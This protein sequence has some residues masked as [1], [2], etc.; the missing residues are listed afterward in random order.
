MASGTRRRAKYGNK[1]GFQLG[2]VIWLVC[3]SYVT[4]RCLRER[5][6]HTAMLPGG[7]SQESIQLNIESLWSGGPFQD[8]VRGPALRL[9]VINSSLL[10]HRSR[11]TVVTVCLRSTLN[12]P[13]TCRASAKLSFLAHLAQLIVRL[14]CPYMYTVETDS[15]AKISRIS[16]LMLE[17]MVRKNGYLWNGCL[18]TPLCYSWL[19][20]LRAGCCRFICRGRILAGDIRHLRHGDELR[21]V[22]G[23]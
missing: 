19:L 21:E 8:P 2:M 12:S 7:T 1:S 22:V 23:P 9:E 14:I 4:Q 18:F 13:K 17:R 6:V 20:F 11:T 5:M 15:I 10:A 16:W 3:A